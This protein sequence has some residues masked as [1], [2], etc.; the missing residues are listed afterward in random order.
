MPRGSQGSTEGQGF[1]RSNELKSKRQVLE[2]MVKG[3]PDRSE[4]ELLGFVMPRMNEIS[5]MTDAC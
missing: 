2:G 3:L 5:M 1:E 4:S